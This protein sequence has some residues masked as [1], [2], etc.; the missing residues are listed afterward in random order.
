MK[1]RFFASVII[2]LIICFAASAF[3]GCAEKP[4]D[5]PAASTAASNDGTKPADTVA[6][7]EPE[8]PDTYFVPGYTYNGDPFVILCPGVND[9]EWECK[10]FYAEEDS[11]DAVV[12]AVFQRQKKIED[13]FGVKIEMI[14]DASRGT[15]GNLVKRD[16]LGGDP[17]YD[18]VMQ[19][20]SNAFTLA[21]SKY[22]ANLENIPY[23]DLHSDVWDQSY[24]QQSSIAG[25]NYFATGDITTMDNDATWVMMFNKKLAEDYDLKIYDLVNNNEW[26]FDKLYEITKDLYFSKDGSGKPSADDTFGIATTIDFTQGLFYAADGKIIRKGTDDIPELDFNNDQNSRIIDAVIKIYYAANKITFDCHDYPSAAPNG[27]YHL[28]AQKMFEENRALFYSEVMQCAIRL[29]DMDTN[30][31]IIPLPKFDENQK[32]YTTHSVAGVTLCAMI[33][34]AI[35]AKTDRFE[36]AGMIMQALA[37]EGKNILT[38]AYYEKSLIAKG[39]RD[40][41]SKDMLPIIFAHRTCDI[42]YMAEESQVY[43]LY[44]AMRTMIKKGQNT[45]AKTTSSYTKKV[46][47]ALDKMIEAFTTAD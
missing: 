2:I 35:E 33:T 8:P 14:V 12:S 25:Q 32:Y 5:D 13:T 21:Q 18:I 29:R 43:S 11:E 40:Y 9:N 7:T 15:I 27:A 42:G 28:T 41:E 10:D 1:N 16:V 22:L 30:Y 34:K 47:K 20:M 39:T 3:A 37:V 36:R 46:N 6:E 24:L 26:T 4:T 44:Q 17:E 23:L 45:L 19:V 31:G 38:P